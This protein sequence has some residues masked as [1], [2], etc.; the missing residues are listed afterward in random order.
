M[1]KSILHFA[2]PTAALALV[3][4]LVSWNNNGELN[5]NAVNALR[6]MNNNAYQPG[7]FLKY[8]IH[9]GAVNAGIVSMN[10]APQ[11]T[12]IGSKNTYNLRVEGE[13]VKSFE[14]AYKVRDKFESWVDQGSQ[15]PLRYAKTVRE[16]RYFNQDLA[17]YDHENAKLRNT[18]GELKIPAYTQDVASAIYYMRN[19][20][21][22]TAVDGTQF[23]INV[24]LDNK[25][26][27]LN[28][29]FKG[30]ETIKTDIGKVKC[31]KIKPQLVVDRVFKNSDAMTVWV[32]D[33][34]NHIPVRIESA[35]RVG[36]IKV[37]IIEYRGLKNNF[38]ALL[39]K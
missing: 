25:V 22:K 23:P 11:S 28:V 36:S 30:R 32:T 26:Y 15:A 31:I 17:I 14:W 6:T 29:T 7:E 34:E 38:S 16:D 1:K 35:I 3:F 9:Y 8:R 2:I 10:V 21:Y 5:I 12:L 39:P 19:L 4:S 37:D 20:N 27:N 13:T 33:D 18:K 24:Y